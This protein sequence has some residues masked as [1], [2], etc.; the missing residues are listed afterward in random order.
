MITL[1]MHGYDTAAI[2]ALSDGLADGLHAKRSLRAK[3][4][5]LVLVLESGGD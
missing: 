5:R 2:V 3:G 4:A 1:E